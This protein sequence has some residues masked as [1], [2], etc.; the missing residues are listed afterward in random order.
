MAADL[1]QM[2]YFV[3]VAEHGN[4]TRAADELHVAQQAVSQQIRALEARNALAR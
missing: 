4:F 3:A 1:R 2:R